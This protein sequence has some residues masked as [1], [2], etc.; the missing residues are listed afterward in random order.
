MAGGVNELGEKTYESFSTRLFAGEEPYSPPVSKGFSERVEENMAEMAKTFVERNK[1]YGNNFFDNGE[2][3]AI[4][5]PESPKLET[6]LDYSRLDLFKMIVGKLTR[7][8]KNYNNGGHQDS[9][10]DL[11]VYAVMLE[12]LDAE[13]NS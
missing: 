3:L 7:Y 9:I 8:A 6:A 11:A 12:A 4:L 5:F 1:I 2:V 10:R 13:I